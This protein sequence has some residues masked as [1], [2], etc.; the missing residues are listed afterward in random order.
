MQS[1][2]EAMSC[3]FKRQ[4]QSGRDVGTTLWTCTSST[5][6]T[7]PA[8]HL[9]E[10]ITKALAANVEV[11]VLCTTESAHRANATDFVVF[12]A[13]GCVAD[14]VVRGRDFFEFL[15]SSSITWIGIGVILAS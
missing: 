3:F 12:S 8:K 11:E 9:A 13:L 2:R 6:A 4:R 7:A 10:Q 5:S 14:D 15:F 1:C